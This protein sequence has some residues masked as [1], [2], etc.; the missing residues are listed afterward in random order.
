MPDWSAASRAGFS[1]IHQRRGVERCLMTDDSATHD[2]RDETH[3]WNACP[4]CTFDS[5]VGLPH[6]Y[7]ADVVVC[8]K[9]RQV[10]RVCP[11][12]R[13]LWQPADALE[14]FRGRFPGVD[15]DAIEAMTTS[16]AEEAERSGS[17]PDGGQPQPADEPSSSVCPVSDRRHRPPVANNA[18]RACFIAA[19]VIFIALLAYL[20]GRGAPSVRLT[21]AADGDRQ[22]APDREARSTR[23]NAPRNSQPK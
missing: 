11:Q 12:D 1:N 20:V 3:F 17:S 13:V 18:C 21:P 9:C 14:F 7:P 23:S 22:A 16:D 2:E 10:I 4:G 19:S 8:P 5:K 15:C 6:N